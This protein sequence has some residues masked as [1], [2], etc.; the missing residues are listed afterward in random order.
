MG[1]DKGRYYS[2]SA[3]VNGAV[4]WAVC[5]TLERRYQRFRTPVVWGAM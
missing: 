3:R 2:R 1:W 4:V 5:A